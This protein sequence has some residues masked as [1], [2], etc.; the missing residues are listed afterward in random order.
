MWSGITNVAELISLPGWI[1]EQ[2]LA[3]RWKVSIYTVQRMRKR[4]EVRAKR[5]GGRWKYRED[6]IQE[7]E[8]GE[9][10]CLSSSG[11]GNGSSIS[12]PTAQTGASAG[13]I[14]Q[15]DRRDVHHSA[16]QIFKSQRSGLRNT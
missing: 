2:A 16:Q 4:G 1:E 9:T 3:A 6:W 15:L 5:I 13:S 12:G 10:P 7:Y 8:D 14:Q 11:L